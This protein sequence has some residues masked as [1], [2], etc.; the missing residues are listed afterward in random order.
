VASR[1]K[2]LFEVRHK[3][4]AGIRET[5]KIKPFEV[6]SLELPAKADYARAIELIPGQVRTKAI[7]VTVKKK[8]DLIVSDPANDVLKLSVVERHKAT[9][10]I[11]LGLVRGFGLKKGALATSVAHDAHNIVCVGVDD[12][13]MISAIRRVA[14]LGGGMVAVKGGLVLAELALPIAGLM[15]DQPLNKVLEKQAKLDQVV[16]DLGCAVPY[17]FGSLSFL[18][19]PVIPELRLTD[20]G[21]VDVAKF[22]IVD[23]YE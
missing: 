3:K 7:M 10:N 17:P 12:E 22:K 2:P 4:K 18:A 11:G 19:L 5:V 6:E 21:L 15:S 20:K 9:G 8:D 13:D 1:G 14:K 23:L 16:K